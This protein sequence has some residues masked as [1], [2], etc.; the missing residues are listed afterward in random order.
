MTVGELRRELAVYDDDDLVDFSGLDFCQMRPCS[1][2]MVLIEFNQQ[3]C[4][5]SKGE[6]T[7]QNLE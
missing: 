6:V 4:R 2:K 5:N 3:V 1:D 7:V